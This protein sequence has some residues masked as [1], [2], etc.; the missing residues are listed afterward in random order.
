[1]ENSTI[2]LIR[3]N[4]DSDR[5]GLQV[6]RFEDGDVILTTGPISNDEA[7][8]RVVGGVSVYVKARNAPD[9]YAALG[10]RAVD[11]RDQASKPSGWAVQWDYAG[12]EP[13]DWK[14]VAHHPELAHLHPIARYVKTIGKRQSD[15]FVYRLVAPG[16]VVAASTE[17]RA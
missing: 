10:L 8:P 13:R 3:C 11:K 15:D 14:N 2:T 9:V 5:D 16:G 12:N 17:D 1:M 7:T 4:A 6:E